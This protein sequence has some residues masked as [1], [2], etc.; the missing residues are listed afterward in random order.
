MNAAEK[1]L[2]DHHDADLVL[3]L[4]ELRRD[5]RMRSARESIRRDYWPATAADACAPAAAAHPMNA[6]WRQTTT[7]WEMVF[8]MAHHGIVHADYLV[9]NS[10]EGLLIFARA[11]P[12]LTELR[13]AAGPR[14]FR[15]AEWAATSTEK[16]RQLMVELRERVKKV[17][18]NRA[19]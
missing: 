4:Y 17:T 11:E 8:G 5:E 14:L 3:R 9:E 12:W 2:P 6:A 18:A 15:H 10:V 13:A 1:D 16:G 19:S 7:Y